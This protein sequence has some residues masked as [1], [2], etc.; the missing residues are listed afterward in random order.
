MRGVL[1]EV[2][3]ADFLEEALS[4]HLERLPSPYVLAT[5]ICNAYITY[6][7]FILDQLPD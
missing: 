1:T 2:L 4:V 7:L 6:M 3:D 5:C